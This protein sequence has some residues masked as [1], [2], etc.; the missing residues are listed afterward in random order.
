[1]NNFAVRLYQSG[2]TRRRNANKQKQL[3]RYRHMLAE[4]QNQKSTDCLDLKH[5][6][7]LVTNQHQT[8]DLPFETQVTDVEI[9]VEQQEMSTVSDRLDLTNSHEVVLVTN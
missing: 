3:L 5:E 8:V 4:E 9:M 1:M 2:K 6:T 7:V